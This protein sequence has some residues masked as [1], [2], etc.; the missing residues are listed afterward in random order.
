MEDLEYQLRILSASHVLKKNF[1]MFW[2]HYLL[3]P[4]EGKHS[5]NLLALSTGKAQTRP[6][7]IYQISMTNVWGASISV[8]SLD[9]ENDL[10]VSTMASGISISG[11][12]EISL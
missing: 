8:L 6:G 3:A 10:L 9:M 7:R 12:P 2:K 11:F 4:F 1:N 5:E